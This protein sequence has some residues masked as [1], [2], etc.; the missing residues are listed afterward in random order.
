[1]LKICSGIRGKLKHET[2]AII[3]YAMFM[4][5]LLFV[6]NHQNIKKLSQFFKIG[7][8]LIHHFKSR[9]KMKTERLLQMYKLFVYC[10]IIGVYIRV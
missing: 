10:K 7:V 3:T 5:F 8:A 6:L 1:M 9:I 4:T 2:L